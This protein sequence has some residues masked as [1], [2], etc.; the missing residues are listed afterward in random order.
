MCG[1][2][3]NLSD[4]NSEAVFNYNEK[5]SAEICSSKLLFSVPAILVQTFST[6][7]FISYHKPIKILELCNL[8]DFAIMRTAH[9]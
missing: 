6:R 2:S 7:K 8:Q 9:L 5:V 4:S 1:R 3:F